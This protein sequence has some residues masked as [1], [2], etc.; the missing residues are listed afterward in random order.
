MPHC[1]F[2][3]GNSSSGIIEAPFLRVPTINIGDRQEG[4]FKAN[5]VI[6]TQPKRNLILKSI[7]KIYTK[8]FRKKLDENGIETGTHYK[9]IHLMKMYKNLHRVK[10]IKKVIF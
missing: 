8:K 10:I 1:K 5:S 9:P 7:E 3:I 4:R 6:D 2:V